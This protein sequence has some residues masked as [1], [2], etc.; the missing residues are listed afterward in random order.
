MTD[1]DFFKT[2]DDY[3]NYLFAIT[4][5]EYEFA[6]SSVRVWNLRQ[7]NGHFFQIMPVRIDDGF[8]NWYVQKC[9]HQQFFKYKAEAV[10]RFLKYWLEWKEEPPIENLQRFEV[11]TIVYYDDVFRQVEIVPNENFQWLINPSKKAEDP[12]VEEYKLNE[13]KISTQD[14]EDVLKSLELDRISTVQEIYGQ[15][16]QEQRNC[17]G[18]GKSHQAVFYNFKNNIIEHI[19]LTGHWS[20]DKVKLANCLHELGQRWDLL[21]QDVYLRLVID[22]KNKASINDYLHTYDIR[23]LS[24]I[25]DEIVLGRGSKIRMMLE[26]EQYGTNHF[27]YM[28][29]QTHDDH[30]CMSLVNITTGNRKEGAMFVNKVE[31]TGHE[32]IVITKRSLQKA[33]GQYFEDCYLLAR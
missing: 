23:K 22:L 33:L 16:I 7:E 5:Y 19:W 17:I 1:F 26:D 25:N 32:K 18:F 9:P 12:N 21:L 28:L 3:S 10:L 13:R 14:L 20:M 29:I 4:N 11:N 15:T 6:E 2:D 30:G 27:D 8:F 31:L 24:D